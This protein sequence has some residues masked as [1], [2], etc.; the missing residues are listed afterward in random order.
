MSISR[1][2]LIRILGG[3]LGTATVAAERLTAAPASAAASAS[4]ALLV[5]RAGQPEPAPPGYDRL[6]LGWYKA[7]V[8]R[9]KEKVK[10][11]CD[12]IC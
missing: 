10:P 1:R 12:L 9:L 4:E 6:P 5:D 3:G 2:E 11:R 7:T 8:A